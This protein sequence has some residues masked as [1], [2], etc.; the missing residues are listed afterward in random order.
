MHNVADSAR[1]RALRSG[2]SV[3]DPTQLESVPTLGRHN[4]VMLEG[5]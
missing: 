2:Q 4:S 5:K 1:L 3:L